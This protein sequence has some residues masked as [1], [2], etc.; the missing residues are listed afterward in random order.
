MNDFAIVMLIGMKTHLREDDLL[1]HLLAMAS[2]QDAIWIRYC[3]WLL[4]HPSGLGTL[5]LVANPD[6]SAIG[7]NG[8]QI[9]RLWN[10]ILKS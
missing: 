9:S 2:P 4:S 5:I 7:F 3:C 8:L 1:Y 6:P 10:T